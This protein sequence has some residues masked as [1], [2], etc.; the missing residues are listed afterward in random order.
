MEPRK[1]T[2]VEPTA[3]RP[4]ETPP[5]PG[6]TAPPPV[7]HTADIAKLRDD[8]E[9][10]ERRAAAAEAEVARFRAESLEAEATRLRAAQD[11]RQSV[12][13]GSP[14]PSTQAMPE[15]SGER[16]L[17]FGDPVT[18]LELPGGA[19][20][21]Y[22][23]RWINDKPGRIDFAKKCGYE[24]IKD[25]KG[26]PISRVVD[27]TT[28]LLAFAM[29]VPKKFYDEDFIAKQ[30]REDET[31]SAILRNAISDQGY[32]PT[33]GNTDQPRSSMRVVTG[34]MPFGGG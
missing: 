30:R 8:K 22:V 34:R 14:S 6:P 32:R 1:P 27:N 20:Q 24:H 25:E 10:M 29:E 33:V 15:A 19:R 7:D 13:E 3:P 2:R 4:P 21:G 23:P 5:A 16:R 18:R 28:G 31:E 9:A 11:A 17:R 12:G 26:A